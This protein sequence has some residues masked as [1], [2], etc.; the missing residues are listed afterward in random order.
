M[1]KKSKIS[2]VEI[3]SDAWRQNRL[4]KFTS[5]DACRLIGTS[6]FKYV[7]EKI[8]E[9]FTGKS[10]NQD[11]D[12]DATRWG[13]FHE[14]EALM[15]FG[16]VRQLRFLVVQQLICY[17]ADRFGGTPDGLIVLRESPDQTEYEVETVEVKCPPTFSNYL[18]L[19]EC[20][21]PADV[22]R[23]EPRYYWQVLDQMDLCESLSGNLVAYHPDFKRGNMKIIPFI[24]NAPLINGIK[25]T[26]PVYEDL[27]LLRE[28]K[29]YAD[30]LFS[31]LREKVIR[32]E[33]V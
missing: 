4:A 17:P 32:V 7:R 13:L 26:Y 1:L 23:V 18:E 28:R 25:K 22:K 29:K 6:V 21:T 11:I 27:K 2:G 10:A 30:K 31:E 20:E 9:E 16:Q 8:G 3:G 15:K 33:N 19:F 5:S 14:A 24:A 12:T